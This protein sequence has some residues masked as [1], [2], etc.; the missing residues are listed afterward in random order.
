M[1]LADL[2]GGAVRLDHRKLP[3]GI[4]LVT[5]LENR[6]TG[7]D[8][9]R[10][11][12]QAVLDRQRQ[13]II[14]AQSAIGAPFP[15]QAALMATKEALDALITELRGDKDEKNADPATTATGPARHD[16]DRGIRPA[17][18]TRPAHAGGHAETNTSKPPGTPAARLDSTAGRSGSAPGDR[19]PD[20]DE[21][22]APAA[23]QPATADTSRPRAG[24]VRTRR[25]PRT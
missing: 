21:P 1:R 25:R 12:Q 11:E 2:P 18:E 13:E 23:R 8:K 9:L 17:A 14:R 15:Q 5:R 4:G 16:D 24:V 10:L 20:V 7:L 6:L 22:T 3:G 19:A